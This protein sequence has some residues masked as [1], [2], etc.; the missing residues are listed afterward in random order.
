MISSFE[1][2]EGCVKAE[3]D[4][5]YPLHLNGIISQEEFQQSIRNINRTLSSNKIASIIVYIIGTLGI[6]A[7]SICL[8]VARATSRSS[9]YNNNLLIPGIILSLIGVF[10]VSI[11]ICMLCSKRVSKT[12]QAVA[13]ESMKYSTRSP[14]SCSWRLNTTSIWDRGFVYRNNQPAYNV[15]IF[16]S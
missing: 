5:T 2:L 14:I 6:L 3:F 8:L 11:R 16:V 1:F 12:Q 4:S 15:S 9:R 13:K 10:F 7:G